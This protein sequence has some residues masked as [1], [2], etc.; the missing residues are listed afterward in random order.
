MQDEKMRHVVIHIDRTSIIDYLVTKNILIP[1]GLLKDLSSYQVIDEKY[2]YATTHGSES[3]KKLNLSD[4]TYK[5]FNDAKLVIGKSANDIIVKILELFNESAKKHGKKNYDIDFISLGTGTAKKEMK[6]LEEFLTVY[7]DNKYQ[8]KMEPIKFT[9]VDL[10]SMLLMDAT[11]EM[12]D[13]FKTQ[14]SN[15]DLK[16]Q[17]RMMNFENAEFDDFGNNKYRLITALGIISNAAIPKIF[18]TL[19]NLMQEDTLLLIDVDGVDEDEAMIASYEDPAS[20][21]F[22]SSPMNLILKAAE[23]PQEIREKLGDN[24]CE[25]IKKYEKLE[26][27]LDDVHAKITTNDELDQFIQENDLPQKSKRKILVNSSVGSKTIVLLYEP[28]GKPA[29]VLG[30]SSRFTLEGFNELLS[31]TNLELVTDK[32]WMYPGKKIM[33]YLLRL[34]RNNPAK[35]KVNNESESVRQ[36]TVRI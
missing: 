10:S 20:K 7:K 36:Q 18:E 3:Y 15:D 8:T 31:K 5:S 30:Y 6:L 22:I 11:N 21:Q 24:I 9:P 33:Y 29:C 4:D 14:L 23:H 28:V 26:L 1:K 12:Y 25:N 34:K 35:S 16:I 32:P 19:E 13:L 27:D 2:W 17:P